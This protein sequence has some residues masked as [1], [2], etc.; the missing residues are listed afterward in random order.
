MSSYGNLWLSQPA[1]F[2][3]EIENKK[4]P[5]FWRF[6]PRKI[7]WWSRWE[8]NPRPI[9]ELK[10]QQNRHFR[11]SQYPLWHIFTRIFFEKNGE[12][13]GQKSLFRG[14]NGEEMG[15]F[16]EVV[17]QPSDS[18]II[19]AIVSLN[20]PTRYYITGKCFFQA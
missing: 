6:D 11:L 1:D 15:K 14:K 19:T 8:V 20:R 10:K 3:R 12:E 5:N 9:K 16:F 7:K 17:N 18:E 4:G 13:M 2:V